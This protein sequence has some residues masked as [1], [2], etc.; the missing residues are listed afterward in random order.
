MIYG[1]VR[2]ERGVKWTDE[3]GRT[4]WHSRGAQNRSQR[5]RK[6]PVVK[7]DRR[8]CLH[9]TEAGGKCQNFRATC[10]HHGEMKG[11]LK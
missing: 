3:N 11:L 9:K 10:P 6:Q 1:P 2:D 4:V 5:N 7:Q 8:K